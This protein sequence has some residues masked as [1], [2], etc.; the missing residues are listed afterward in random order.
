MRIL[1]VEDEEELSE[2]VC[3]GLRRCSYAVDAVYDGNEALDYYHTYD[4]FL[5][6]TL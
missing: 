4:Y 5:L 2:T 3:R 6:G 1:Y